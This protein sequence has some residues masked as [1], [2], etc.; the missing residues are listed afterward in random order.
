MKCL[1][2]M[3]IETFNILDISSRKSQNGNLI[4]E[5]LRGLVLLHQ[6]SSKTSVND[7]VRGSC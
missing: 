2:W 1:K 6:K 7:N 4:S 3:K 5:Y